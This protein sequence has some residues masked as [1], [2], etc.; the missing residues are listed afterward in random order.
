M[1]SN[2]IEELESIAKSGATIVIKMDGSRFSDGDAKLYTL[3][4]SGGGLG[5]DDFFRLDGEGLSDLI[6]A[7]LQYYSERRLSG[8]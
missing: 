5:A 6:S 4:V 2:Q 1:I 7:E 8:T 3:M